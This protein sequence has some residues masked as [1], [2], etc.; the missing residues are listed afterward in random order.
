MGEADNKLSSEGYL[1]LIS[2]HVVGVSSFIT[3]AVMLA[4]GSAAGPLKMGLMLLRC[5]VLIIIPN[6]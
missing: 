5:A 4:I 3:L 6:E 2:Q 1:V